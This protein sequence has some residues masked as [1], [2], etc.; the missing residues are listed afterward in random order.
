MA[1]S[2]P[3][4]APMFEPQYQYNPG[5]LEEDTG[6]DPIIL[7]HGANQF[8]GHQAEH[9]NGQST[10]GPH[11]NTVQGG[12]LALLGTHSEL[13]RPNHQNPLGSQNG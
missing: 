8:L 9:H 12:G 11:G 1:S 6:T 5:I 10:L 13:G 3:S 4:S 7:T 2:R